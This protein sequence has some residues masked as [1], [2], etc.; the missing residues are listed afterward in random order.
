MLGCTIMYI[1]PASMPRYHIY[2]YP[3]SMTYGGSTKPSHMALFFLT[4]HG[5]VRLTLAFGA[6]GAL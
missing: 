2:A 4:T 3:T 6:K 5:I 1:E